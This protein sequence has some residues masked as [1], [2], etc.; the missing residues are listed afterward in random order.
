MLTIFSERS[1]LKQ[2]QEKLKAQQKHMEE[3]DKHLYAP[4]SILSNFGYQMVNRSFLCTV[5]KLPRD[6]AAS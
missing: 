5:K 3:L 4:S 2:L 6:R 1:R